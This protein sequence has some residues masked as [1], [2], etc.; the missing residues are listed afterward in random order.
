M[1]R[2][3][4][5]AALVQV[6]LLEV[7]LALHAVCFLADIPVPP[8]FQAMPLALTLLYAPVTH[9]VAML[10]GASPWGE[11]SDFMVGA[12]VA[13]AVYALFYASARRLTLLAL[14]RD[15]PALALA[16]VAVLN[17]IA[18]VVFLGIVLDSPLAFY[19]KPLAIGGG[20]MGASCVVVACLSVRRRPSTS[21]PSRWAKF[22]A[23]AQAILLPLMVYWWYWG[24]DLA[25]EVGSQ[26]PAARVDVYLQEPNGERR[27]LSSG[28]TPFTFTE[29]RTPVQADPTLRLHPQTNHGVYVFVVELEGYE[30]VTVER[31]RFPRGRSRSVEIRF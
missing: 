4:V 12:A 21:V 9:W 17:G 6:L 23:L 31:P 3:T 26:P 5:R 14:G 8:V 20:V 25:Y 22:A 15:R 28:R 16:A 30:P 27:W 18:V 11:V 2:I 1:I 7:V 24:G 19:A 10:W 13:F 29:D